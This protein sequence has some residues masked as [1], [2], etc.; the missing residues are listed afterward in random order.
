MSCSAGGRTV[1]PCKTLS[2]VVSLALMTGSSAPAVGGEEESS[3]ASCGPVAFAAVCK[4]LGRPISVAEAAM[5]VEEKDGATTPAALLR[6]ARSVGFH[7]RICRLSGPDLGRLKCPAILV[8]EDNEKKHLITLVGGRGDV[9]LI[10]DPAVGRTGWHWRDDLAYDGLWDGEVI[11]VSRHRENVESFPE[12]TGGR[13]LKETLY[14]ALSGFALMLAGIVLIISRKAKGART[15]ALVLLLVVAWSGH[16]I[17]QPDSEQLG[18]AE[19][20]VGF[21]PS[22]LD[23]GK[24]FGKR[25]V[26]GSLILFNNTP[27]AL[28][29]KTVRS[30]CAC[31]VGSLEG[32]TLQPGQQR[33]VKVTLRGKRG[34][35]NHTIFVSFAE[36]SVI[37]TAKVVAEFEEIAFPVPQ[38]IVFRPSDYF[39][40]C[41]PAASVTFFSSF[42]NVRV[43]ARNTDARVEVVQVPCPASSAN[44]NSSYKEVACFRVKLTPS[45]K[46]P[47]LYRVIIPF[48]ARLDVNGQPQEVDRL[49][50]DT[51]NRVQRQ[52]I[53]S[54]NAESVSSETVQRQSVVLTVFPFQKVRV[55]PASLVFILNP[56]SPVSVKRVSFKGIHARATLHAGAGARKEIVAG[57]VRHIMD[58]YRGGHTAALDPQALCRERR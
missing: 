33:S 40:G 44:G 21:N 43:E 38:T 49:S 11:L 17:S 9:L 10:F 32:E 28:T 36:I 5:L 27:S 24:V 48:E 30:S 39:A 18:D 20:Q 4:L 1:S 52:S 31:L 46:E 53:Q 54:G 47:Q 50:Q 55:I 23:L 37:A 6:G 7:A 15:G 42:A 19:E 29:V 22:E 34:R 51:N 13:S 26:E 58:A 14:I 57:F 3:A 45:G 25:T 41:E 35:E 16:A 8:V 2:A 12:I 56:Q